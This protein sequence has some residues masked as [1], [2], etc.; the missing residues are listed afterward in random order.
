MIAEQ[1]PPP[2][3]P[4]GAMKLPSDSSAGPVFGTFTFTITVAD[5]AAKRL[6]AAS[7]LKAEHFLGSFKPVGHSCIQILKPAL[8]AHWTVRNNIR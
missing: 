4:Y 2:E 8:F 5:A 6:E 1:L 3:S 7:W